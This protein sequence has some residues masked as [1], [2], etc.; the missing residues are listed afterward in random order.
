MPEQHHI[1]VTGAGGFVGSRLA[2]KARMRWPNM[3]LTLVGHSPGRV[4]QD[5]IHLL[6]VADE[7]RVAAYIKETRPTTVIHLA[8]VSAISNAM[9]DQRLTWRVNALGPYNIMMAILDH[10]PDCHLVF[11]SSAEVY[12]RPGFADIKPTEL[13]LLQ[14][15][16]PYASAKAAADIVIQEA[17]GRGLVATVMRPFN[18][19]GPGQSL[20]F[21]I[22]S[23]CSQIVDIERGAEPVIRVGS[24]EDVR[25]FLHVDDVID[26]YL[27]VVDRRDALP[28]GAVFNVASG[29]PVRMQHVLDVL[30]AA[31]TARMRVEKDE[32]RMRGGA[33]TRS[34]GDASKL[35]A[36]LD[37]APHHSLE[38]TLI[39][40]LEYWR[41]HR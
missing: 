34:V 33:P 29:V 13:Q 7:E 18:H 6:D 5:A 27:E 23:F 20:A 25:D 3:R 22:P 41:A 1:M 10:V 24:L 31:S 4:G 8:A 40:T 28:P 38:D 37:W 14:P 26:A 16:N 19:I 15:S 12:G 30:I 17:A 2:A 21:A 9:A 32:S 35:R 36:M 11:V 39:E